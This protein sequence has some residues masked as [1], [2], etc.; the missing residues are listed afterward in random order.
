M[1]NYT[2]I[3]ISDSE[4]VFNYIIEY[5]QN[6]HLNDSRLSYVNNN[7]RI[8]MFGMG[9]SYVQKG[10]EWYSNSDWIEG[11]TINNINIKSYKTSNIKLYFPEYSVDTYT[12][13]NYMLSINTWINGKYVYLGSYY[14]DRFDSLAVDSIKTFNNSRYYEYVTL[15]IVDPWEVVYSDNWKEFR[16]DVCKEKDEKGI[17]LNN[18][19]A[20]LNFTL[21]PV[22][23]N[24]NIYIKRSGYTGGQNSINI[25]TG[26][27]GYLQLKEEVTYNDGVKIKYNIL[28]NSEYGEDVKLYL[29]ETYGFDCGNIKYELIIKDNENV[30]LGPVVK[31]TYHVSEYFNTEDIIFDNWNGYEEGMVVI[32]S[33]TFYDTDNNEKLYI[34]SNSIPFTKELFKYFVNPLKITNIDLTNMNKIEINTVNKIINNIIQ[35]DRPEDSKSNIIQPVFFRVRDLNNIIIHPEVTEN[36]CI[37]LDQYKS[38]VNQFMIKI[39]GCTFK[40]IGANGY[41]IIFKVIGKNLPNKKTSGLYY[42]LDQDAEFI[43]SGKYTYEQ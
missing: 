1:K 13:T 12:N 29:K 11:K 14:I 28:F 10:N 15:D 8:D 40:Q 36:I 27:Q 38:K 42:I 19:G 17:S 32:G 35:V 7:E 43:T 24:G 6:D 2:N 26:G 34:I 20:Q 4:H 21:Y 5:S 37:N 3:N 33:V 9:S 23:S 22:E 25:Y 41:G 16:V 30:Y 18:T 31:E 39:E